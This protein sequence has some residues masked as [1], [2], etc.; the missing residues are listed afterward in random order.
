MSVVF[1][2]PCVKEVSRSQTPAPLFKSRKDTLWTASESPISLGNG[3]CPCQSFRHDL[4]GLTQ[5]WNRQ[6]EM[7][8]PNCAGLFVPRLRA[9]FSRENPPRLKLADDIQFRDQ[10]LLHKITV[11]VRLLLSRVTVGLVIACDCP[12]FVL[13]D[14]NLRSESAVE[15]K[16]C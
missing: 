1:L 13:T 9:A 2:Q 3:K 12:Y 11:E 16:R 5:T 6:R 8:S 7:L 4:M 10:A 14:L 15:R